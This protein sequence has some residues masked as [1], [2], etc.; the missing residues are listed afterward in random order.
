MNLLEVVG[1]LLQLLEVLHVLLHIPLIL[2]I[3]SHSVLIFLS[4]LEHPHQFYLRLPFFNELLVAM[5]LKKAFP[6][7]FEVLL[8]LLRGNGA[9][10]LLIFLFGALKHQYYYTQ[11]KAV[12]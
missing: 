3:Q 7:R 2:L 6:D 5:R 4:G 11:V 12:N 1:L 9:M 10:V 8:L